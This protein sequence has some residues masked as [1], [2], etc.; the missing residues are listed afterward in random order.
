M[1]VT[2]IKD[3]NI[4]SLDASKLT[5]NLPA[6]SGASLTNLPAGG[7]VLQVVSVTKSDVSTF[8]QVG[9]TDVP[10]LSVAITPSSA[11]SK[12]LVVAS[13]STS[14][15]NHGHVR[16]VRDATAIGNGVA[17][18]LRPGVFGYSNSNTTNSAKVSGYNYLDSPSTTSATTY[19]IQ[20]TNNNSATTFRVNATH[21]D[22][23][24]VYAGRSA[25]TITLMEI[26][27]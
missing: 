27:A 24:G 4:V 19:K 11:T 17:D 12:I 22:A 23:N 1:S 6:I 8:A 15:T 21:G 7:K 16:M 13:V 5:G 10:G 20:I 26:G 18:G 14:T 25:S 3:G 2:Q 9:F